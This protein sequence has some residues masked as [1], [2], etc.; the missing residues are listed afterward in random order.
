MSDKK[1]FP[2]TFYLFAP[3]GFL[4]NEESFLMGGEAHD[5]EY[6]YGDMIRSLDSDLC[7]LEVIDK[8]SNWSSL[9]MTIR[10]GNNEALESF[11]SSAER[12]GIDIRELVQYP[13]KDY[14]SMK[15]SIGWSPLMIAAAFGTE[16]QVKRVL[17]L[18]ADVNEINP[19]KEYIESNPVSIAIL[20]NNNNVIGKLEVLY[21]NG[22]V[23]NPDELIGFI[24]EKEG[25]E[26]DFS[27]A[28]SFLKE[29][30]LCISGIDNPEVTQNNKISNRF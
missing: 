27:E 24:E 18:G 30:S 21:D 26:F 14:D 29:K 8:V 2:N 1:K 17:E 7:D 20:A 19:Y 3:E 11:V 23:V 15:D 10:Y 4:S 25:L 16:Y 5:D 9:M 22:F 28:I 6:K 13:Y 12:Q